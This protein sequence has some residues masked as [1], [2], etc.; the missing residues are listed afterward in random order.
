M[1]AERPD[2]SA[3]VYGKAARLLGT[4]IRRRAHHHARPRA[5]R[6][7]RRR[8]RHHR[9]VGDRILGEAEVKELDDAVGR[10]LDVRRLQITMNDPLL[11]RGIKGIGDLPRHGQRL[12]HDHRPVLKPLGQGVAVDQLHHQEQL[13][14]RF[15]NAVNRC[16]VGV[17]GRGQHAR[18]ASKARHAVGVGRELR[19]QDLQGDGAPELGIARRVNLTHPA[20]AEVVQHVVVRQS[21]AGH[22]AAIPGD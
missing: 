10:D 5:G 1:A 16:D 18:F 20:R 17:C 4:H 7:Y 9:G 11:V 15:F 2:I 6:C 8:V 12:F 13:P 22:R 14:I 19:R 3:L 21:S